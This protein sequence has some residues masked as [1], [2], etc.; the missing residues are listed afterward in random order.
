MDL[1]SLAATLLELHCLNHDQKTKTEKG[2]FVICLF[3]Q[4]EEG[5]ELQVGVGWSLGQITDAT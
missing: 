3:L 2:L 5:S 4:K 1:Y